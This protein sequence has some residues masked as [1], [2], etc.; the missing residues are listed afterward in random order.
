MYWKV[1]VFFIICSLLPKSAVLGREIPTASF[2]PGGNYP[3]PQCRA[4]LRPFPGDRPLE[5][6]LYRNAMASY[7]QCVTLYLE[8]ARQDIERIRNRMDKVVREY[9]EE[10]GNSF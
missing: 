1:L 7:R 3:S 10:S 5:W 6:R 2:L 9:N 4:P 8:T